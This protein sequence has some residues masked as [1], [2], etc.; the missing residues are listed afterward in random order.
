MSTVDNIQAF[1][2][3]PNTVSKDK[4]RDVITNLTED[5]SDEWRVITG[6][7]F[8]YMLDLIGWSWGYTLSER[9]MSRKYLDE[10]KKTE[11]MRDPFFEQGTHWCMYTPRSSD[12]P[13]LYLTK[14]GI[15]YW[16]LASNTPKTPLVR[17]LVSRQ[18][19]R[20]THSPETKD[21]PIKKRK[22]VE[23]VETPPRKKKNTGPQHTEHHALKKALDKLRDMKKKNTE[24][25]FIWDGEMMKIGL[26]TKGAKK[27]IKQLQT[28][29]S[30]QLE[31]FRTV[32]TDRPFELESH[33]HK[34]FGERRVNGE[35]FAVSKKEISILVDS[36]SS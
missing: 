4:I 12:K 8:I 15:T 35:W 33:L 6:R 21:T 9:Q 28:G 17:S 2:T 27:R 26:T 32:K 23:V 31:I 14:E 3:F 7:K 25:Y 19:A 11:E 13:R 36:L 5:I 1:E 22:I 10:V 16:V 20:H 24:V 18:H 29:S 30:R 34:M